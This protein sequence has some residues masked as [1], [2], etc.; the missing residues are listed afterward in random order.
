MIELAALAFSIALVDKMMKNAQRNKKLKTLQGT[1]SIGDP[2]RIFEPD[3]VNTRF[4]TEV[5]SQAALNDALAN[6]ECCTVHTDKGRF[7][8]GQYKH[9]MDEYAL[10]FQFRQEPYFAEKNVIQRVY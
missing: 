8:H 4:G 5:Y 2:I 9:E 1:F 10:Q 3:D 7:R 6:I